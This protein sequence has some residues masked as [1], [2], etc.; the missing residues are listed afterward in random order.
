[1]LIAIFPVA[2]CPLVFSMSHFALFGMAVNFGTPERH[3]TWNRGIAISPSQR[4]NTAYMTR[5]WLPA[6]IA[7][8][9]R[10]C[11]ATHPCSTSGRVQS[12]SNLQSP[13]RISYTRSKI[14]TT[15]ELNL[16]GVI[17]ST[18]IAGAHFRISRRMAMLAY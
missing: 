5:T 6:A 1:M 8:S 4:R 16:Q 3:S 13:A 10:L 15:T 2:Y 11:N 18:S 14:I 9:G 17:L 7:I 12:G